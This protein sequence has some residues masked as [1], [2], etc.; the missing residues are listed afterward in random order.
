MS[1]TDA[2]PQAVAA[3]AA[4]AAAASDGKAREVPPCGLTAIERS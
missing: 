1:A 3:A 4:A 2:L